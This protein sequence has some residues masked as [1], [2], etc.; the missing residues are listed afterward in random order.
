M[1]EGVSNERVLMIK[2]YGGQIRLTPKELGI[3]GA[4]AETERIASEIPAF[5]PRQFANVDNATS[6]RVTTAREILD[7]IPG[8]IV[9]AV[10]SGVGTG[11]TLVGLHQG[12]QDAGCAARPF[13][14]KPVALSGSTAAPDIECKA[15]GTEWIDGRAGY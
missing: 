15:S 1:P 5:L 10:A 4:I 6:H 2:A 13:H 8:G 11:G 14:A 7:Q 9:D 12:F 3:H